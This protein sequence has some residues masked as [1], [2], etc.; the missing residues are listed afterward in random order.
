MGYI[1]IHAHILQ[2]LDDGPET[3]DESKKMLHK[4]FEEG[5]SNIVATPH[6]SKGFRSYTADDVLAQC[7]ILNQYAKE[8]FQI[9]NMVLPGQEIYYN[10]ASLESIRSGSIMPLAG[11]K[12]ILLEFEPYISF[13]S[14][15]A[16]LREVSMSP[17]FI[18]LAHIERYKCLYDLKNLKQIRQLGILIQ[19]NYA[20]IGGR[21]Y[22]QTTKFCRKCLFNGLVDLLGTDMHDVA[23]R[24]SKANKA[25]QW[26]YRNLEPEYITCITETNA[27]NILK[28]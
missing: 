4:A 27:Q 14:L 17:Y 11:S 23:S 7:D 13:S 25:F 24:S 9:D 12:Y 3:I 26:M 18:I 16:G 1:D 22:N 2:G 8:H 19:M 10:A 20:D 6:Y 15:L 5:F 21:W 28:E